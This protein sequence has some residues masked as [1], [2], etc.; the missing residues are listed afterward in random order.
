MLEKAEE[1]NAETE[2]N[3]GE[4][5]ENAETSELGL[6]SG[7]GESGAV[8]LAWVL[9]AEERAEE[10]HTHRPREDTSEAN[11]SACSLR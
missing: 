10:S 1:Q 8:E 4:D 9:L 6:E 3:C 11:P 2:W 7:G 5:Q